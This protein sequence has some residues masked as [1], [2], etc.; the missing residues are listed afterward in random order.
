MSFRLCIL[1]YCDNFSNGLIKL[2]ILTEIAS[3]PVED[4]IINQYAQQLKTSF[5]TYTDKEKQ[6][7]QRILNLNI[8]TIK[9]Y[10]N[11]PLAGLCQTLINIEL[12]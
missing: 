2:I 8:Q 6:H 5:D 9:E 1:L 3:N 7:I 10:E 11:Q 12:T 4:H